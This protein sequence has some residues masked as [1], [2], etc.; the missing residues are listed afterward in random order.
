M[1]ES[2]SQRRETIVSIVKEG[3]DTQ[4]NSK[5]D[6]TRRRGVKREIYTRKANR[7]NEREE[8]GHHHHHHHHLVSQGRDPSHQSRIAR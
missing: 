3:L 2:L 1:N 8:Q 6:Y 4:M 7:E 5:K